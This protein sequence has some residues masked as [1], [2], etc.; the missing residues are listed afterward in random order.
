MSTAPR[1]ILIA[2]DHAVVRRGVRDLHAE[3]F[4]DATFGEATT[5]QEAL[6]TAWQQPWDLVVLDI[7]MPGRSGLDILK[8]LKDAQPEAAILVQT[9][10]GEDQFAIRVLKAG[11][12][13]YITKQSLPEEL[14]RAVHKVLN[15]GRYVSA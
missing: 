2:D 9:M 8:A 15:G 4:P 14:I 6:E 13:G 7:S 3:E 5:A 10:H 11:G 1:K 12:S